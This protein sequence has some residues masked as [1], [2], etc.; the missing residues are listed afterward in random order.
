M[1]EERGCRVFASEYNDFHGDLDQHSYD[2][3]LTNIDQCDHF[4]LLIGGR[5]GGWYDA[6]SRVSITQQEYR[7]A[8]ARH[9][10]GALRIVTLVRDE[11]WQLRQDHKALAKYIASLDL[12]DS[13]RNSVLG[14]PSKYAEDASFVT[15][16]LEEVG[17]NTETAKAV[18]SGGERPTGNW[19]HVFRDFRDV[20]DVLYPLAFTGQTADE[21]AYRKA[22]QHELIPILG[23]LLFK[24]K[25]KALDPSGS[26]K[27]FI[28][29]NRLSIHERDNPTVYIE[30][31]KWD[32]FSS[33]FFA[34]MSGPIEIVVLPDALTSSIFL[35]Y[36]G[37]TGAYVQTP[38]YTALANLIEYIRA[39]NKSA[40]TETLSTII[41]HSPRSRGGQDVPAEVPTPE[42]LTLQHLAM[43]WVDVIALCKALIIH[44]EGNAFVM[45]DLMPMSPLSDM[46]NELA[47]EKLTQSEIREHLGI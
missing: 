28:S 23:R 25:G 17:R 44:L 7:H 22:L 26:M 33:L 12:T 1:L 47:K 40:T 29:D 4:I 45:P 31:R 38:A 37:A 14:F 19:V 46:D 30:G 2:A 18:R 24:Y 11:V 9:Q 15:Q 35:N 34:L 36:D 39:I 5:V 8:Y 20:T 32:T 10:G 27:K 43:R 16:F 41:A 3:C 42:F 13:Q 21:A 6:S